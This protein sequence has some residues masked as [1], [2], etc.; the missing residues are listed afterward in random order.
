M[1]NGSYIDLDIITEGAKKGFRDKS[2]TK[3]SYYLNHALFA[4]QPFKRTLTLLTPNNPHLQWNSS[5]LGG[6]YLS[7]SYFWFFRDCTTME[8]GGLKV[9]LV[10]VSIL[11]V[12]ILRQLCFREG[13]SKLKPSLVL[14]SLQQQFYFFV[15]GIF[16]WI[17]ALVNIS[18]NSWTD[19]RM[20][21]FLHPFFKPNIMWNK[22]SFFV[23]SS[24]QDPLVPLDHF[25]VL[26]W[27]W[28]SSPFFCLRY[29]Q[30]IKHAIKGRF[31]S[32][33][34]I[35]FW[36]YGS[37]SS[38]G[39]FKAYIHIEAVLGWEGKNV[40]LSVF[41]ISCNLALNHH[42]FWRSFFEISALAQC[43]CCSY[44]SSFMYIFFKASLIHLTG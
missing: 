4:Q 13:H 31:W 8:Q 36:A 34:T 40:F 30:H 43:V 33:S 22:F 10:C 24:Y 15:L 35:I 5:F 11:T 29:E 12:G 42:H 21:Q 27:I 16:V 14:A 20:T 2:K 41:R 7:H 39:F 25:R 19:I 32:T 17:F 28:R 18:C 38:S 3:K 26:S 37:V 9:K 1:K 44:F 6:K 23:K